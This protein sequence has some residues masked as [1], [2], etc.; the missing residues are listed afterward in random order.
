MP[1]NKFKNIEKISGPIL[2]RIDLTLQIPRLKKDDYFEVYN[3]NENP[4]TTSAIKKR[5]LKARTRQYQRYKENKTNAEMT[6]H[7]I[8]TYCRLSDETKKYFNYLLKKVIYQ[9][10]HTIGYESLE[11]L[12][13]LM[14]KTRY[15]RTCYGGL[16]LSKSSLTHLNFINYIKDDSRYKTF[17]FFNII[18]QFSSYTTILLNDWF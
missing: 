16:V 18:T 15:I 3:P 7:D 13:I 14:I 1:N 17:P 8:E 11:Q 5:V 2:D 10:D 6:R 9:V 4:Y 12:L